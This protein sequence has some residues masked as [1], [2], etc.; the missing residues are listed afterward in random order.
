MKVEE[1]TK[2]PAKTMGP[3]KVETRAPNDFLKKH[4]SEPKQGESKCKKKVKP[5]RMMQ[6]VF[7]CLRNGYIW[8]Q[9]MQ[10]SLKYITQSISA[11]DQNVLQRQT[12]V[13]Q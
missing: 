8:H 10:G 3:A 5:N 13:H 2:Y 1:S 9:L 12:T 6:K 4:E 11:I 7:L